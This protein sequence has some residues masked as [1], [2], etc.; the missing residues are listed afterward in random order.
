MK[1]LLGGVAALALLAAAPARA[2]DQPVP[3]PPPLAAPPA[4]APAA[5]PSP[6]SL[7][8]SRRLFKAMHADSLIVQIS[9]GMMKIM[10]NERSSDNL[11]PEERDAVESSVREALAVVAPEYLEK[12]AH[13][14]AETF[15]EDEL[16]RTVEFYET[17]AGQAMLAK[18]PLLMPRISDAV[19]EIMPRMK[20]ET[21]RRV[22]QK[23][24]CKHDKKSVSRK[25]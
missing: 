4:P 2:A 15:T 16:R 22:C 24:D 7:E 10:E 17:P 8:L 11:T 9:D 3:P 13:I 6:Q 12:A 25:S 21:L 19:H 14:Y 23:V 18:M 5:E 20:A 1:T